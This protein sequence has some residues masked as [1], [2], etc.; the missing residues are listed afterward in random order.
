MR[1]TIMFPSRSQYKN[2]SLPAKWSFWAA[3]IGIPVGLFSLGLTL[4][5]WTNPNTTT[6]DR[7]LI[8]QVAQELRY[9]NTFLTSLSQEVE[10]RSNSLPIGALKTDALIALVTNH[11]RSVVKEAYG[12]EKHIYQHAILLKDLGVALGYPKTYKDL[13][14]FNETSQ[15][16]LHDIHFLNNFLHWYLRPLIADTLEH[17]ELYSLGFHGFPSEAFAIQGVQ[18][19]RL[20][21]FKNDGSPIL[22]YIDYL[23]LID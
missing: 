12:E 10:A 19:I 14:R 13:G 2:W 8:L 11:Y 16:T 3:F 5:S 18:T 23:G 17:D 15:Y 21:Q 6:P 9:N 1:L 22:E 4:A 20:K 7:R